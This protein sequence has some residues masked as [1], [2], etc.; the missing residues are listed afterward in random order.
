MNVKKAASGGGKGENR[1]FRKAFN[2]KR[3]FLARRIG[4]ASLAKLA[5]FR[6][7]ARHKIRV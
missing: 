7:R 5:G 4:K 2:Y 3:Q 6:Y 1:V